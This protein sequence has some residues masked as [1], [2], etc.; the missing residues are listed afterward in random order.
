M[1]STTSLQKADNEGRYLWSDPAN[2]FCEHRHGGSQPSNVMSSLFLSGV[3]LHLLLREGETQQERRQRRANAYL[4]LLV[5][6]CTA[7][8]HSYPRSRRAAAMDGI[9]MYMLLTHL[10]LQNVS[11]IGGVEA[12]DAMVVSTSV[13]LAC[14]AFP[15]LLHMRVCS[16]LTGA[17]VLS[18]LSTLPHL[19]EKGPPGKA[20]RRLG[21]LILFLIAFLCWRLDR[22]K[23]VCDP[24][25]P[26]QLHSAW[27]I[28]SA[29][30]FLLTEG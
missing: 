18:T 5:S 4:I 1:S 3:G 8:M 16:L 12:G 7:L 13:L 20:E 19:R 25:S 15:S 14:L 27:H 10:T 17:W 9:S 11:S 22:T 30:G 21:G 26:F 2:V 6:A 29:F 23:Q 24:S 28:L